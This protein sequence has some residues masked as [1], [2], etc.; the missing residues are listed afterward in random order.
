MSQTFS[1]LMRSEMEE[2]RN[3]NEYGHLHFLSFIVD[4]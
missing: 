2:E 4:E 1:L 3:E